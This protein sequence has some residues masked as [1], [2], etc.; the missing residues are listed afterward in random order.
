M[1]DTSLSCLDCN[2][3]PLCEVG[4]REFKICLFFEPKNTQN[5]DDGYNP[6]RQEAK[7]L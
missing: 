3:L 6:I 4:Q 2:K 1:Y 7:R 5:M